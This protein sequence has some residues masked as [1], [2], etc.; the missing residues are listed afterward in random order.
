[1]SEDCQSVTSMTVDVVQIS[2]EGSRKRSG[3][4]ERG[5]GGGGGGGK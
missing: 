3:K 2:K 1:M 5:G 4:R